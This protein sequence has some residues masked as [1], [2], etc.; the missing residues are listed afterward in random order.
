MKFTVVLLVAYLVVGGVL[1][2]PA[3]TP[4]KDADVI[5][6]TSSKKINRYNSD[7]SNDSSQGGPDFTDFKGVID[8]GVG[9]PFLQPHPLPFSF[10]LGIFDAFEDIFKRMRDQ[11]LTSS[12]ASDDTLFSFDPSKGNTTSTVKIVNGRKIE[13]NKTVF[14][15]ED[16]L[17]KVRLVNIRPVESGEDIGET[18]VTAP[19]SPNPVTSAPN[20][21]GYDN[22]S[23]ERREPLEK[24]SDENEIKRNID[25]P[26]HI[27]P[28]VLAQLNLNTLLPV[29]NENNK[30]NSNAPIKREYI[31]DVAEI[32]GNTE[33]GTNKFVNNKMNSHIR[34]TYIL[35]SEKKPL[36]AQQEDVNSTMNQTITIENREGINSANIEGLGNDVISVTREET[37]TT[38]CVPNEKRYASYAS[39]K[40]RE[41]IS[42]SDDDDGD[43][44]IEMKPVFNAEWAD[45]QRDDERRKKSNNID[46]YDVLPVDFLNDV[47]VNK[48]AAASTGFP[49]NPDAEIIT[50]FGI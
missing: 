12:L 4:K 40:N 3:S 42:L 38:D 17:F 18:T 31:A 14:G 37:E 22:E 47:A 44:A 21:N 20:K 10:N 13:V 5:D 33:A 30:V 36:S 24:K 48:L 45:L 43:N 39:N 32:Y 19:K 35:S 46:A 9:Y 29:A 11:L 27:E 28:R 25:E 50:V 34:K 16:S 15:D 26:E 41:D 2:L 8:T 6:V 1:S 7:E 49:I 23:D